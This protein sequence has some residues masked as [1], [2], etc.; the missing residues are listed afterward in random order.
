LSVLVALLAIGAAAYYFRGQVKPSIE[1][2][3]HHAQQRGADVVENIKK[4]AGRAQQSPSEQATAS[5]GYEDL[6][7]KLKEAAEK[8][9]Q[10]GQEGYEHVEGI[11]HESENSWREKLEGY[12]ED[13]AAGVQ[14]SSDQVQSQVDKSAEKVRDKARG[15]H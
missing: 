11:S 12:V 2:Q 3:Y 10:K 15:K 8:A 6:S 13:L 1:Q 14:P 5:G 7:E 9:H 4:A